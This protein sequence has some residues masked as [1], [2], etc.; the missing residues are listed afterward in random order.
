MDTTR[1]VEK[2]HE[3]KLTSSKTDFSSCL[4]MFSESQE[5]TFKIG[6][7]LGEKFFSC[8]NIIAIRGELGAGKTTLIKGLVSSFIENSSEFVNSPTFTYLNTYKGTRTIHH[9]DLYRLQNEKDFIALG[10]LDYLDGK[11]ICCIEWPER[12][13]SLLPDHTIMIDIQYLDETKRR[14]SLINYGTY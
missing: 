8:N 2:K 14:I 7:Q 9:F 5:E 11:E 13:F 1:E 3:T 10:F 6:S 12:I 4:C